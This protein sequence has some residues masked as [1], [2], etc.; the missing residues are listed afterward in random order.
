MYEKVV[1]C[2]GFSRPARPTHAKAW[3]PNSGIRSTFASLKLNCHGFTAA[4]GES[5]IMGVAD[6][7]GELDCVGEIHSHFFRRVRIRAKSQGDAD[8]R[9]H[10]ED[11]FAGIH[12]LA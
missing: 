9:G 3:T 11:L 7:T 8:L 10:L 12:F 4:L 5:T 2:P 6:T 1:W